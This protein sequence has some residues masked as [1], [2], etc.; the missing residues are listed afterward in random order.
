MKPKPLEGVQAEPGRLLVRARGSTGTGGTRGGGL[1]NGRANGGGTKVE[2]RTPM[3]ETAEAPPGNT[4]LVE[5]LSEV[6]PPANTLLPG[7]LRIAAGGTG[8]RGNPA[9][10]D[11]KEPAGGGRG[12]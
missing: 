4:L 6:P 1:S 2:P 7:V 5:V 9:P 12:F 10:A 3:L 8:V 11:R